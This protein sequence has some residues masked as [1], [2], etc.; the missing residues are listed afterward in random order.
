MGTM[1]WISISLQI[2]A[3]PLEDFSLSMGCI[4]SIQAEVMY[5]KMPKTLAHRPIKTEGNE[6]FLRVSLIPDKSKDG[7]KSL[8]E[9]IEK[10]NLSDS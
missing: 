4:S 6:F 10:I 9:A 1:P 7:F 8:I 2:Q 5:I 3:E